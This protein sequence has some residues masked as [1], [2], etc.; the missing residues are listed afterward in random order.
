M[1]LEGVIP[2]MVTPATD[3]GREIDLNRTRRLARHLADEGVHGLL[4]AGSTGEGPLLT[5][6]QRHIL[7]ETVAEAVGGEIPVI[8]GV[9]AASTSQSIA[10]AREAE[11]AGA[12]AV[13][14]LPLHLV[15]VSQ[16]ELYAY[17][18]AISD[19]VSIPTVLY[20]FPALT[21][22]QNISADISRRLAETKNVIGIKDS[23]GD[24]ENTLGYLNPAR[25][26]FAV[27]TG[28]ETQLVK[29]LSAGG[30][31]TICSAANLIP[32]L[33]VA[34]YDAFR[35]GDQARAERLVKETPALRE[36]VKVGTFPAA[37]KAG[38]EI[39]GFAVGPPFAP[40]FPLDAEQ[41]RGLAT[42]LEKIGQVS[43]A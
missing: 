21:H 27:F 28:T 25:L 15:P 41:R 32:R 13:A 17:F 6:K 11:A 20:N 40:V 8:A 36:A 37:I 31:G 35:A 1:K 2:A 42:V 7:I 34:I 16:D 3:D 26:D 30:A 10:F 5:N 19:S 39:I 38:C 33:L 4:V 23:G 18:A 9:G 43:L 22:G 29:L 12:A 14:A 24:L